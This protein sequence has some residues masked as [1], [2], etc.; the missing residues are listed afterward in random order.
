MKNYEKEVL[1]LLIYYNLIFYFLFKL[2][3]YSFHQQ[4]VRHFEQ[5]F[6]NLHTSA[7]RFVV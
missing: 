4:A 3:L 7:T 5:L 1:L 2:L 6:C